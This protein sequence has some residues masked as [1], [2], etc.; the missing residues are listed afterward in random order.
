VMPALIE[1]ARAGSTVGE[2]AGVFRDVF[3]E[4]TEPAP[5]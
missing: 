4:F 1:A 3:G 5:W 2:M